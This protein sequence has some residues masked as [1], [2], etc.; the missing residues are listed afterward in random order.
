[1][2]DDY[3]LYVNGVLA[4]ANT[5]G[6]NSEIVDQ[7]DIAP[8]LRDGENVIAIHAVDGGWSFPFDWAFEDVLFDATIAITA[9]PEADTLIGGQGAD[10]LIA[11]DG[12]DLLYGGAGN[13]KIEGG[14]GTDTAIFSGF[15]DDYSIK[16][17]DGQ[18]RGRGPEPGGWQ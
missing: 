5:D 10:V 9:P 14:S 17:G 4:F 7:V 3:E 8:H 13:D 16:I 15:K 2:D 6:G 12:D 18:C 11:G 1:M